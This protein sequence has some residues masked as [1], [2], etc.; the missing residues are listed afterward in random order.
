MQILLKLIP[1]FLLIGLGYYLKR[2]KVFDADFGRTLLKFVFYV[3]APAL[4]LR[5]ISQLHLDLSLIALI[6]LPFILTV[7]SF[8]LV[9]PLEKKIHLTPKQFAVFLMATMIINS[10]FTLPFVISLVG[11][12]GAA[13]VSLFNVMNNIMVFGWVYSIAISYGERGHISKGEVAKKVLF[14]PAFAS[15]A[16]ALTLNVSQTSIPTNILLPTINF[17]ADL[18]SPLILI[19]LGL[20]MEIKLMFPLQTFQSLFF[21]MIGGLL[22]GVLSVKVFNLTGVDR[23][24]AL[25][26]SA[27]PVGFNTVTFSSLEKLDDEF[28][29]SIVSMG[30]IAGL[31]FMSLLTLYLGYQGV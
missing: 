14:S 29:A 17:L 27:S 6:I 30:L 28:A 21:R 5:A 19:A 25:L 1:T 7:L 31:L 16:I 13:R 18:T 2:Q 23:L 9:K 3:A 24:T 4:S 12:A 20:I 11:D 22:V 10:G 15:L 26:L 8:L